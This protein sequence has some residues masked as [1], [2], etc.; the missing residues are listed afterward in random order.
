MSDQETVESCPVGPDT[1]AVTSSSTW[2]WAPNWLQVCSVL[3]TGLVLTIVGLSIAFLWG[4]SC[5]SL[6]AASQFV[7][8]NPGGLIIP[9]MYAAAFVA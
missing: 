9:P 1:Q 6:I 5:G 7:I 2:T 8:A 4:V 3:V